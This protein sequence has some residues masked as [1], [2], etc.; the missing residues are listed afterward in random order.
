MRDKF[1]VRCY[2]LHIAYGAFM[3]TSYIVVVV[4][5]KD[6]PEAQK[7][8]QGL[9]GERLI[10]C[11]NILDGMESLFWWQG[12][13]DRSKEVLLILKTKKSLFHKLAARVK[14]LHSYKVPEIIALPIVAGSKGYLDWV[15]ESV[16]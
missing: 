8:A 2:D 12:K 1:G 11:A 5:A 15:K 14:S 9:L 16:C 13:I 3:N 10:A 6:R 4:T 7:I